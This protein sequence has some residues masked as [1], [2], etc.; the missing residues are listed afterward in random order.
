MTTE[1]DPRWEWHRSQAL[2]M[3]DRYIKGRC[4]HLDTEPVLDLTGEH[5]AQLC[6]T[7]DTQLP[8]ARPPSTSTSTREAGE[9]AQA[10]KWRLLCGPYV[11]DFPVPEQNP[12]GQRWRCPH[13]NTQYKLTRPKPKHWCRQRSAPHGH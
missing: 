10:F 8:A 12:A 11:C 2:G 3:P 9:S 5:V 6:R 13:C 7:C 4:N 1:L